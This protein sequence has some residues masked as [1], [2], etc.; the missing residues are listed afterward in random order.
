MKMPSVSTL[1]TG[2]PRIQALSQDKDQDVL[3][4][5]PTYLVAQ[6]PPPSSSTSSWLKA[7]LGQPHIPWLQLPPL[8]L[9]Q[10][11]NRHMSRGSNSRLLAQGNSGAAMCP[12]ELYG[13][14]VIEVNKY[15]LVA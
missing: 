9:G 11:K 7:A 15:H 6:L 8:G 10:L 14:W 13:L 12:M 3:S 2:Y 4:H 1:Q 5:V